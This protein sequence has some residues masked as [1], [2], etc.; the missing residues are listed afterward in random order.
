MP[1]P[2]PRA[3]WRHWRRRRRGSG[4]PVRP[5]SHVNV[6]TAR[7]CPPVRT[8]PN[9]LRNRRDRHASGCDCANARAAGLEVGRRERRPSP[10]AGRTSRTTAPSGIGP[11]ARVQDAIRVGHGRPHV[12]TGAEY[13][14]RA[15]RG[16]HTD[17]RERVSV[18]ADGLADDL[19]RAPKRRRHADSLS[20]ATGGAAGWS[21][22]ETS[23]RPRTHRAADHI[24]VAAI[25]DLDHRLQLAALRAEHG[26]LQIH[27]W[28][29]GRHAPR[30][31][32]APA[33]LP[34]DD[35]RTGAPGRPPRRWPRGGRRRRAWP[36]TGRRSR[37]RARPTVT[38]STASRPAD[39]VAVAA[40]SCKRRLPGLSPRHLEVAS[41]TAV[42]RRS[43]SQHA[44]R[45]RNASDKSTPL[46][47]QAMP[48][49]RHVS[50]RHR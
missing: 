24:E 22:A 43:K 50:P 10:P 7:R 4:G 30:C 8:L 18:D 49:R 42:R 17:H 40:R 19:R 25:D 11:P 31:C 13:A 9:A 21:S 44:R 6:A 29:R 48:V 33:P 36:D 38:S 5:G 32:S 16:H 39:S 2:S 45:R 47:A 37:A 3:R 27:R 35:S 46:P 20:T 34:G 14:G 26:G 1:P 41:R 28:P 23:G 15:R 12:D